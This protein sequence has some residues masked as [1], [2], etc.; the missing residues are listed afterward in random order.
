MGKCPALKA[1]KNFTRLQYFSLYAF[2]FIH[3]QS[4]GYTLIKVDLN[5]VH[6]K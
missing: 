4:A 3:V 1:E 5:S 6:G 2:Y